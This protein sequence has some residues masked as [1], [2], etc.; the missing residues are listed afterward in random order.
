MLKW[1]WLSALVVVLDQVTKIAADAWLTYHDP[2]PVLPFFNL[3][4]SY[5]SGAAFSFLSDAGGW[6]R[7]FFVVLA[8]GVSVV[9]AVW[10][11]RLPTNQRWTAM[12]LGLVLG[13]AIGNVIDRLLY[14]H[15]VD[16]LDF[17][18]GQWHWPTFNVADSAI[19]IG[20]AI[21]II[22]GLFGNGRA[23]KD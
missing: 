1:A 20:V 7:W 8:L 21:L 18:V 15:V 16:F 14:G 11:Y 9:I 13:G 19:T 10:M 3:L 6:Q 17:Y 5:N 12:A 4:L 2:V 23:A 22:D